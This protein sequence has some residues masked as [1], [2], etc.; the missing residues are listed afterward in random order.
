[1]KSDGGGNPFIKRF[2]DDSCFCIYDVNT[3]RIVE[4]EKPVYDIIARYEENNVDSL[5]PLYKHTY[6]ISDLKRGIETIRNARKE[7]GLFSSFRPEKVTFG[8]RSAHD[9]KNL[10]KKGL[11]QILLEITNHC[12]LNC[13]YCSASGKYTKPGSSPGNMS[14]ET[15]RR[16]ID[17]FFERRYD[18]KNCFISFF[19]FHEAI[20]PDW[21]RQINV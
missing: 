16:S 6:H 14:W 11:N 8:I 5:I 12:N 3:N 17:F 7:H 1:M 19:V 2:S 15:C 9:V 18:S 10:H 13:A 20:I 21:Q 4:V